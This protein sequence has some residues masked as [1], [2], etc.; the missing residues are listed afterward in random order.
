Q[1]GGNTPEAG[2]HSRIRPGPIHVENCPDPATE[3]RSNQDKEDVDSAPLPER[4]NGVVRIPLAVLRR[5]EVGIGP[6]GDPLLAPVERAGE[7]PEIGLYEGPSLRWQAETG[8]HLRAPR[9]EVTNA[10]HQVL[11]LVGLELPHQLFTARRRQ[12]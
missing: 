10:A 6:H 2:S 3:Q 12:I 5:G 4:E 8:E 1:T 7:A 11:A 9:L